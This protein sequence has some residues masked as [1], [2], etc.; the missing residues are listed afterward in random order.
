MRRIRPPSRRA[1]GSMQQLVSSVAVKDLKGPL[2]SL[3]GGVAP[4]EVRV[5]RLYNPE[6]ITQRQHRTQV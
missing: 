2:A 4:F 1:I 6:G 5:H 3:S